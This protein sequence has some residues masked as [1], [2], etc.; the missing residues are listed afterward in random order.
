[1]LLPTTDEHTF[2]QAT[3]AAS[4]IF[5]YKREHPEVKEM[6]WGFDR[7]NVSDDDESAYA[8]FSCTSITGWGKDELIIRAKKQPDG[9]WKL[10][11]VITTQRA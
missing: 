7:G 11:H 8:I 6:P 5:R 9:S 1:M 2:W 10:D 4:E 3:S